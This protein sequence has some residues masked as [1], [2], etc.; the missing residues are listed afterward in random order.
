MLNLLKSWPLPWI[1]N[2]YS[3][4]TGKYS[5]ILA[6]IFHFFP[7]FVY[8]KSCYMS[9]RLIN[10]TF[11]S[12]CSLYD[13]LLIKIPGSRYFPSSLLFNHPPTQ[14]FSSHWLCFVYSV[15]SRFPFAISFFNYFYIF[16]CYIRAQ[17]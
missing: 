16:S 9:L 15:L 2:R 1:K 13:T 12:K 5:S 6:I 11:F 17:T 3:D 4:I 8:F 7:T 14:H 10:V